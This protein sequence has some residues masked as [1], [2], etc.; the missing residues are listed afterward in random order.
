MDSSWLC[1][2]LIGSWWEIVA[3]LSIVIGYPLYFSI[4]NANLTHHSNHLNVYYS[5]NLLLHNIFWESGMLAG[6]FLFC[7]YEVGN[8]QISKSRHPLEVVYKEYFC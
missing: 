2:G 6:F 7:I 3:I 1:D 5:N 4:L 8:Q